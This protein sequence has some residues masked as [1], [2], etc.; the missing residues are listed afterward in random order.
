ML[1]H[2]KYTCKDGKEKI[3]TYKRVLKDVNLPYVNFHVLRH[4]TGTW[5]AKANVN[6]K[7][8]KDTLGHE[9]IRTTN[10]YMHAADSDKRAALL[11]VFSSASSN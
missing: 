2:K 6:A 4:T 9:D 5:L 3:L 7:V 10:K 8:I 11:S 1:Y